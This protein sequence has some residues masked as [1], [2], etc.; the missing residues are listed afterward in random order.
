MVAR[1]YF[2]KFSSLKPYIPS[3]HTGTQ[4]WR[5]IGPET[6]G[7][8]SMEVLLGIGTKGH[9]ATKHSHPDIDQV[10]YVLEG[11]ARAE[12]GGKCQELGPGDACFFPAGEPHVFT[13]ISDEPAKVLVIYSPP[14]VEHPGKAIAR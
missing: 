7:A 5:I 3:N 8:K 4:N 6:V 9:G 14:Y 12:I 1:N 11:R 10:C 13:V 2:V